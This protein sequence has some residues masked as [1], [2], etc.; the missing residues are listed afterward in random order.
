MLA[1]K[2]GIILDLHIDEEYLLDHVVRTTVKAHIK[3]TGAEK[4]GYL[5]VS[6]SDPINGFDAP[7]LVPAKVAAG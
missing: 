2:V 6:G 3:G 5:Q 1:V 4:L 7:R